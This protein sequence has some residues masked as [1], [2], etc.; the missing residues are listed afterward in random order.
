[1]KAATALFLLTTGIA[2]AAPP[3]LEEGT[4][5]I[6][7]FN[8]TNF[9]ERQ[10]ASREI[11]QFTTNVFRHAAIELYGNEQEQ[12]GWNKLRA[13]L[14]KFGSETILDSLREHANTAGLESARRF[15]SAEAQWL[16]S[17]R[18]AALAESLDAPDDFEMSLMTSPNSPGIYQPGP[19][20][21]IPR[22][23]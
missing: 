18:R 13:S 11:T 12:E 9:V 17:A 21:G 10:K 20:L 23:S 3:T 22:L 5:I 15:A 7:K 6:E 14:I 16:E 2:S 1:M 8:S 4:R 19:M